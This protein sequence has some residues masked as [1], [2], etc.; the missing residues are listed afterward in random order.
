MPLSD[1]FTRSTSDACSSIDR[2]LWMIPM[3]PCCAMAMARRDSVTVSI[4]ALTSG[5]DNRMLRVSRVVMST[6]VGTTVECRGTSS[7]SSKVSAVARSV[8]VAVRSVDSVFRSIDTKKGRRLSARLTTRDVRLTTASCSRSVALFVLLPAAARTRVVAADLRP[9]VPHRFH[10]GVVAADARSLLCRRARPCRCGGRRCRRS[11]TEDGR[12]GAFRARIVEDERGTP[13]GL[14]T[15]RRGRSL[16]AQYR[17]QPPEIAD[18]FLVHPILHRLEEVEALLL[19]LDERIALAVAAEADAL[20]EVIQA[21]EVILPLLI[22]DLQ[23][24]V[25]LDALQ[26]VPA[27]QLLL[28]LVG[29]DDLRP[30]LVANLVRRP[31]VEVQAGGLDREDAFCFALERVEIPLLE[32]GLARSVVFDRRVEDLFCQLHQ[33]A[34]GVERDLFAVFVLQPDLPFENLTAQRID[35]LAL[36]VHHVV[37]LEQMLAD[38]EVLR[39]DLLLRAFDRAGHHAMLDRHAFFHA[40]PLHQA[41]DPIRAEDAHQVVFEREIEARR[42]RIALAAGAS[43]QLI[44]DPPR[45][46][47]LGR[48]DVEAALV[49]NVL[50][51]RIAERLEVREDPRVGVLRHAVERVE[52]KEVDELLVLDEA[53]LPL[54]QPLGDFLRQALLARHELGVAAEQDVRAAA[55]HVGRDRHRALAARLRDELRLLRVILGVEHDVLVRAAAGRRAALQAAPI[56]HRRQLLRLLD[57]HGA[58][59]NRTSLLVLV[60]NLPDDRVPFL[61]LGAIDEIGVLDA[62]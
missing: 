1:R 45:L 23:H 14:A 13:H 18:D 48:D 34:A 21:V 8:A 52:V 55:G 27:D 36:L 58:D 24:D 40:E 32:I 62:A 50:V 4:A 53:L 6:C 39:L 57:R 17:P 56:E 9:F 42:A 61:F 15:Y 46:V 35:V 25:A 33:V 26:H 2:F 60:E 7:T 22:D 5:T 31:I 19:V 38:G 12:R 3:P 49:D 16:L 11:R 30:Q 10:R 44:V 54:R 43:A 28:L 20:L 59:Q 37:V 51:L 41:G 47:A 29:V